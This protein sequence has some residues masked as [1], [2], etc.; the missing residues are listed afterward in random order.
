MYSKNLQNL[1]ALM[2]DKDGQFKLDMNDDIIANTDHHRM[3]AMCIHEG[4]KQRLSPAPD[5]GEGIA[6]RE[7]RWTCLISGTRERRDRWTGSLTG[8]LCVAPRRV[9]RASS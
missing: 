9:S 6:F 4:T 2:I 1:L 7:E 5:A 3:P 8:D